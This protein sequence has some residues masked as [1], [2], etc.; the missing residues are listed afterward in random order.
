MAASADP[1]ATGTLSARAR[2]TGAD[3]AGR[4]AIITALGSTAG[5]VCGGS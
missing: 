3:P 4:W 2:T 5:T 1:S